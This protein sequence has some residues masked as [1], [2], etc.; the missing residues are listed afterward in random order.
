MKVDI[1][2]YSD[3]H[4]R[5]LDIETGEITIGEEL[6]AANGGSMADTTTNEYPV[7]HVRMIRGQ[8]HCACG[9][10]LFFQ[11]GEDIAI[12]RMKCMNRSCKYHGVTYMEP[13]F[14]VKPSV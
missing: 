12:R 8:W 2:T 5:Y 6:L 11:E 4:L 10:Q 1:T 7:L 3:S 9:N 13:V 14:E